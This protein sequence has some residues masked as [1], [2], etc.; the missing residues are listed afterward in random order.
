MPEPLDLDAIKKRCD[1]ATEG[2]WIEREDNDEPAWRVVWSPFPLDVCSVCPHMTHV[3]PNAAFIAHARTD[4]PAL[5]ARVRELEAE[6][7][8]FAPDW[9]DKR[10]AELENELSRLGFRPFVTPHKYLGLN[11]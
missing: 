5:V 9:K 1:A 2:P 6:R 11:K 4:V 8:T 7:G 3:E 10:I